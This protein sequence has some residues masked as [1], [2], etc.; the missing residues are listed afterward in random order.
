MLCAQRPDT[1]MQ[2]SVV[3]VY[4]CC[5]EFACRVSC[6]GTGKWEAS[7]YYHAAWGTNKKKNIPGNEQWTTDTRYLVLY[8]KLRHAWCSGT[9]A[10][11][12][13]CALALLRGAYWHAVCCDVY[14]VRMRCHTLLY[15]FPWQNENECIRIPAYAYMPTATRTPQQSIIN[16]SL[17]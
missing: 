6:V 14:V 8:E 7:I 9:C 15:T 4:P 5:N 12:A 13:F 2:I 1:I 11:C 10:P 3:Y 17:S 16:S